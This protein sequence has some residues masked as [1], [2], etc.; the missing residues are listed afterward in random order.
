MLRKV[1]LCDEKL[2]KFAPMMS[3]APPVQILSKRNPN[4]SRFNF[5][6]FYFLP[7][8]HSNLSEMKRKQCYP[9]HK[10][11]PNGLVCDE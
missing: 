10:L 6:Y 1:L 8:M 2:C 11:G 3:L 4:N 7:L 5:F 9:Q